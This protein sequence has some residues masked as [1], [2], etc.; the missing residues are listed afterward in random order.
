[1]PSWT[2]SNDDKMSSW[3]DQLSP[4]NLSFRGFR[5]ASESVAKTTSSTSKDFTMLHYPDRP[6]RRITEADIP[7][8]EECKKS[9]I[10]MRKASFV[11]QIHRR[12][13]I[14]HQKQLS[15][16]REPTQEE[17]PALRPPQHELPRIVQ[18]QPQPPTEQPRAIQP[19]IKQPRAQQPLRLTFGPFNGQFRSAF[20]PLTP[21][22]E[23]PCPL[24]K[25]DTIG[26]T[27]TAT[28][29]DSLQV[30]EPSVDIRKSLLVVDDLK[31]A[32]EPSPS[33]VISEAKTIKL[34]RVDN[35]ATPGVSPISSP[36]PSDASASGW[37]RRK[38]SVQMVAIRR[39]SQ[40]SQKRKQSA[41]TVVVRRPSKPTADALNSHPVHA[42]STQ[43][44]V[45]QDSVS[46]PMCRVCHNGIAE[47]SGTCSSCE[48]DAITATPVEI[49]P[50]FSR[51]HHKPTIKKYNRP[52]PLIPQSLDG[53][54]KLHRPSA[55][56]TSDPEANS[57]SPPASPTS[58]CS[59]PA[60]TVKTVATGPSVPPTPM[61]A[62]STPEVFKRFQE[63]VESRAKA[64]DSPAFDD[65]WMIKSMTPEA[66]V[67]EE[68]W[69]DY[70]FDEQNFNDDKVTNGPAPGANF[71]PSPVNPGPGWI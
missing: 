47:T 5:R 41:H 4:R 6:A 25:V 62:L 71:V 63:E 66:D 44:H 26:S 28:P 10:N 18:P 23:E 53:I 21:A 14:Q 55:S 38:Q 16:V 61:S 58:H 1:M 51:L 12:H 46:D 15:P 31:I 43:V 40:D 29:Q 56:L 37:P 68:D 22:E 54:A 48:N 3:R 13:E 32:R 42:P 69:A 30:P 33:A 9:L 20:G 65:P 35:H 59:S 64:D 8:D 50:N 7:S 49:S 60:E 27:A 24:E 52:P 67:Y 2:S 17:L 57:L 34:E 39:S 19:Q 36:R 45:R 70:Y 11:E